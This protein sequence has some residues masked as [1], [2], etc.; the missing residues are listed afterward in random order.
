[1]SALGRA[2][3]RKSLCRSSGYLRMATEPIKTAIKAVDKRI[4]T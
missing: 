1:V 2:V 3:V 4:A